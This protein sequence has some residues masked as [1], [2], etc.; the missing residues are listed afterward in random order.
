MLAARRAVGRIVDSFRDHDQFAILAF[1]TVTEE[2]ATAANGQV[3]NLLNPATDRNRFRAVQELSQVEARGGTE[4]T[5]A[6]VLG[7]ERLH[8]CRA[9]GEKYLVL[10][11]D[12]QVGNEEHENVVYGKAGRTRWL[13]IRPHVR[14]MIMN[15]VDHPMGGGEGRSS[16]G[17]HPCSPW[18]MPTKG[19]RTRKNKRT[20]RFIIKRRVK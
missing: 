2:I 19:Y 5:M 13:G 20:D 11:T 4:L 8:Q 9:N 18:G 15:P 7:L 16:G 12:G 3:R 14:G 10:V 6:M 1:D 17:R